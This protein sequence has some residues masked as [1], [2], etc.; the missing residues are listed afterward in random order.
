MRLMTLGN[1]I[2][3]K[4]QSTEGNSISHSEI[5]GSKVAK[6]TMSGAVHHLEEC[7]NS[8][9]STHV[10]TLNPIILMQSLQD[11]K[12]ADAISDAPFIIADG[13]G[14][15]W[16]SQYLGNPVPE[17]IAGYDLLHEL[18]RVGNKNKWSVYL[19][20][21]NDE[22]VKLASNKVKEMYSDIQIVGVHHGYFDE[23]ED[24][25]IINK[26]KQ[27]DPQILF[28]A[29]SIDKQEK[30]I[31]KYKKQ[32]NIPIMMGVGGSFDV[33]SGRLKRAPIIYQKLR[34]EWFYRL[35][36]EP[37]RY[38]RMLAIPKFIIKIMKEKYRLNSRL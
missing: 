8:K 22:I 30:W 9:K 10:I 14:I 13:T 25:N 23:N 21:A 33:L 24:Q 34:L 15:V 19:L 27:S 32:L 20:G 1:L 5:L 17:R 38:K 7:I 36:Q 4:L 2:S 26:V 35:I 31:S 3:S 37:W 11:D 28:V 29:R 12:L 16:A 6:L 18:L